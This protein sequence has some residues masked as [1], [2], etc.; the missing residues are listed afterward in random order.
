MKAS[1]DGNC[2]ACGLCV[3]TCPEVF[4]LPEQADIAGVT[5]D[6]VSPEAEEKCR[7]AADNCPAEAIYLQ[8]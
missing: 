3:E 8:E 2:T 6:E 5:M 1:I 4:E 7:E